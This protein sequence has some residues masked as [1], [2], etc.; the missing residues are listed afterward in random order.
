M[1]KGI[2][3]KKIVLMLCISLIGRTFSQARVDWADDERKHI[4]DILDANNGRLHQSFWLG[5]DGKKS[6]PGLASNAQS[7]DGNE[8]RAKSDSLDL[9]P[10]SAEFSEIRN[11]KAFVD[12]TFFLYEWLTHQPKQW[13]VTAPPGFGKSALAK[14]AVQFLNASV[15]IVDGVERFRDKHKTAAYDLFKGTDIFEMKDF[16]D[17]HFQNYAVVYFDLAPLSCTTQAAFIKN[18]AFQIQDFHKYLR[19]VIRKMMSYYPSL[20]LH[21]NLTASDRENLKWYLGG[22]DDAVTPNRFWKSPSV[23]IRLLRK[24]LKRDVIVIVDAYDALC[25]PALIGELSKIQRP[26]LASY[27]I[28]LSKMVIQDG[29][30]TAL[31]LGTFKTLELML[32]KPGEEHSKKITMYRIEHSAFSDS[33]RVAKYFG[34]SR[35]EVTAVLTKHSMQD[36]FNLVDNLLNGHAVLNSSLT[37]FNTKSVMSYVGNRNATPTAVAV[38]FTAEI[39][40]NYAKM[41]SNKWLS[42]VLTQCIFNDKAEVLLSHNVPLNFASFARLK[43]LLVN[44]PSAVKDTLKLEHTLTFIKILQF[45]GLISVIDEKADTCHL[46]ASSCSDAELI[47]KYSFN[48]GS[49]QRF[50][51]IS[52]D[53]EL[54]MVRA[55][56]GLAPDDDSMQSLGEI[57]HSIIKVK[58]PETEYQMKALMYVYSRKIATYYNEDFEMEASIAAPDGANLTSNGDGE[59]GTRKRID[60]ILLQKKKGLG[61]ILVSKLNTS[62]ISVLKEM[63]ENRY[64]EI[65]DSDLR[66]SKLKIK[67]KVLI[68]ISATQ[69]KSVEIAA[70]VWHDNERTSLKNVVF[71]GT[72]FV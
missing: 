61:F 34:L 4:S 47:N 57:I 55:V 54:G 5:S 8:C 53:N 71:N 62:A 1:T 69:N 42:D 17:K 30:S 37:L 9:D 15:E 68:G 19:I 33:E 11:S 65:L 25:K 14:M 13:Y 32:Q 44:N 41:F 20:S 31:Y 36:H 21:Q 26:Y 45:L 48:S 52:A 3:M 24:C 38:P 46:R 49:V 64:F 22:M 58:A 51:K 63:S 56:K 28:N 7:V 50:F 29:Q 23:L 16:F 12:K 39:L 43:D 40:R 10:S 67:Q 27:I 59:I 2:N 66:F 60:I 18:D 70:E 6:Q 35:Q 72:S